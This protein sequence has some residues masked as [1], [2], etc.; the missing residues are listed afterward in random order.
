MGRAR[1]KRAFMH[2]RTAKAQISLR[3]RAVCLG[4]SLSANRIMDTTECM[5]G[6][7]GSG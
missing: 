6:E 3:I 1:R 5:N 7:S 4:S 2:M